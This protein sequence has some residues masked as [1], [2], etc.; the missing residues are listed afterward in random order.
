MRAVVQQMPASWLEE[1][2]RLGLDVFDEMWD[3][4]LHVVPPPSLEHQELGGEIFAFLKPLLQARG[5][6]VLYETG[7]YRPGT[8]GRDY[9]VPDLVFYRLDDIAIR[10]KRGL[11]GTP[12]AVL[13]IR[14]SDDETYDKF[15]FWVQLAVPEIVVIQPAE[16]IA[17]VYRLAGDHYI[18]VSA[19]DNGRTHAAT[20]DVRFCTVE[21]EHPRLRVA[22][23]GQSCEA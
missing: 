1:R 2:T 16:R 9:R 15:P 3:G 10:A 23:N 22:C 6:G 14:S 11:E 21:G 18:A 19:D 13:E 7:V 4:V 17:E 5:L 12:L 20:I 8:D